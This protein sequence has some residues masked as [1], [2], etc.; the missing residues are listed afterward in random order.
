MYQK[1]LVPVDGSAASSRGLEEAIRFA[2]ATGAAIGL[3]HVVDE[4]VIAAGQA[5]A[6][7]QALSAALRESGE[8]VLEQAEALVREHGVPCTSTLLGATDGGAAGAI[9]EQAKRLPADVI[10]MGTHGRRGLRR[11][12]MGSDAELVLR[13]SPVPGLQVRARQEPS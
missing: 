4:F 2:K 13:S 10:V 1:I 8:H 11:L 7:W 3:V 9:I 6:E 5:P 12:T